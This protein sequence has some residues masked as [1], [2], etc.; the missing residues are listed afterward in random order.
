MRHDVRDERRSGLARV[1]AASVSESLRLEPRQARN[2]LRRMYDAAAFLRGFLAHPDQVGSVIPSSRTL[3]QRL[4]RSARANQARTI[5][6]LGPGT[7]GTTRALLAAA[8]TN[9]RFMAIE[10]SRVFCARLQ[11]E[12]RDH[13]LAVECASAEHLR[14]LLDSHGMTAP[15]AIVSG[16]PFS[17]MPTDVADR[18]AAVIAEVLPP[19]G[20]FVAYQVRAHVAQ[21]LQPYLGNPAMNWELF[22]VPPVRV[23]TWTKPRS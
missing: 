15:D 23:F 6:E 1:L 16:I 14:E 11:I 22:N 5:V 10:L 20:R 18:I 2:P 4:V 19:G 17:T 3:E 12:L 7:G 9:A 13:R 21:Y 8:P